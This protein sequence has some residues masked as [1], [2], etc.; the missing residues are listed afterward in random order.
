MVFCP[1]ILVDF[2]MK[3]VYALF[4][5]GVTTFLQLVIVT[6]KTSKNFDRK[7]MS[8]QEGENFRGERRVGYH[9]KTNKK[10]QLAWSMAKGG[11]RG[12]VNEYM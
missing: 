12:K 7:N 2:L 3:P 6:T 4:S 9:V 8:P 1:K 10:N 5:Q 11:R